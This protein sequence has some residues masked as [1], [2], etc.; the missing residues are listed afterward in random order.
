MCYAFD[1]NFISAG[2]SCSSRE[3]R[4]HVDYRDGIITIEKEKSMVCLTATKLGLDVLF[5]AFPIIVFVPFTS[6]LLRSLKLLT[7]LPRQKSIHNC[8]PSLCSFPDI[9]QEAV[10]VNVTDARV[11]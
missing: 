4:F 2:T 6:A 9:D 3:G 8:L 7:F 10:A 11:V 5:R 1:R